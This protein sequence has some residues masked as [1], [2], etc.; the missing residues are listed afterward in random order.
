LNFKATVSLTLSLI[1]TV[2]YGR[3]DFEPTPPQLPVIPPPTPAEIESQRQN[4]LQQYSTLKAQLESAQKDSDR[5]A[6]DLKVAKAKLEEFKAGSIS[7]PELE[8]TVR[9]L[10]KNLGVA[11]GS[12]MRCKSAIA[13]FSQQYDIAALGVSALVA[14]RTN[15]PGTPLPD[16]PDMQEKVLGFRLTSKIFLTK[17]T[18]YTLIDD[19]SSL[20][21]LVEI[22]SLFPPKPDDE[23]SLAKLLGSSASTALQI[24]MFFESK[25]TQ[26]RIKSIQAYFDKNYLY[27]ASV[28][29]VGSNTISDYDLNT[30]GF[31]LTV[32]GF[33]VDHE[34]LKMSTEKALAVERARDSNKLYVDLSFRL[35][36]VD[37]PG[38][39]L[40]KQVSYIALSE[41]VG[42]GFVSLFQTNTQAAGDPTGALKTTDFPA[43]A[44]Q[45]VN[46]DSKAS[47]TDAPQ[48]PIRVVTLKTRK[49]FEIPAD[50][51]TRID[52]KIIFKQIDKNGSAFQKSYNNDE[53][54][55]ISEPVK[56]TLKEGESLKVPKGL[57]DLKL[58]SEIGGY[59]V[60][61]VGLDD[62]LKVSIWNLNENIEICILEG[63]VATGSFKIKE[64]HLPKL[65]EDF[66]KHLE[67][68]VIRAYN[69]EKVCIST[70]ELHAEE[71]RPVRLQSLINQM[72][73]LLADDNK[74]GASYIARK[75]IS[76]FPESKEAKDVEEI[77]N[78]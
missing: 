36:R 46:D 14:N 37:T 60:K 10:T 32:Q 38:E 48:N 43:P 55:G 33:P 75:I 45:L 71:H 35:V 52:G 67:G 17:W 20:Q 25:E 11:Q 12:V 69:D 16:L 15:T 65:A 19:F 30:Q 56:L 53:I 4:L 57:N 58:P 47:P 6:L 51:I 29:K 28:L 66:V 7:S 8:S 50:C 3:S 44:I 76:E 40:K 26:E 68:K 63:N 24:K 23:Q 27:K 59:T 31:T 54:L 72:N 22:L 77:A 34:L 73:Q 1:C 5:I 2:T 78:H 74:G 13:Q 64:I 21:K 70:I 18:S 41:H 49:T 9:E 62:Q 42:T 61:S 39:K